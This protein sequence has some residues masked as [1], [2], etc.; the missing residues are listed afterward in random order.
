MSCDTLG[1]SAGPNDEYPFILQSL[2][3]YLSLPL[4]LSVTHN[5]WPFLKLFFLRLWIEAQ[6]EGNDFNPPMG[7]HAAASSVGGSDINF[8]SIPPAG[9]SMVMAECA[10]A[11]AS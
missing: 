3:L 10:C 9:G 7:W 4:S 5:L 11:P 8:P 6:S 1:V 2:S